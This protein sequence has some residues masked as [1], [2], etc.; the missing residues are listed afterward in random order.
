[1]CWASAEGSS[2]TASTAAASASPV[3]G[4]AASEPLGR[5]ATHA[6]LHLLFLPGF[7]VAADA[8]DPAFTVGR[9]NDETDGD[10]VYAVRRAG[11]KR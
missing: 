8:F 11:V 1:L 3:A 4:A 5:L 7:T 9:G 6:A 2:T 10:L